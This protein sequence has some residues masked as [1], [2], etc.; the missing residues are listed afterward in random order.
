MDERVLVTGAAG[1]I[2]RAVVAALR[3][4]GVPVTAVDREPP[5]PSWDEGVHVVTGD[6]AEQEVC[7]AAFETR[8]TAVVHL[9]ALTSVLRSVDAPM[10]KLDKP[11]CA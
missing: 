3:G 9:A 8:P 4:R 2:G 7:I 11:P 1:F 5:D 6:L 10:K